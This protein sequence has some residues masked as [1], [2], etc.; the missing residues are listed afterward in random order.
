MIFTGSNGVAMTF[1]DGPA[2]EYTPHILDLLRDNGLKATFCVI[3]KNA[4]NHPDLIRRIHYEGHTLCNHSWRHDMELRKRGEAAIRDDLAATNNA[5]R[6]AVPDAKIGYFRAPGGHF[7]NGLVAIAKS[8]GMSSIY[9]DVDTRD[10]E[11]SKYGRGQTMVNHIVSTVQQKTRQGSIVLAH[12]YN[13][14]D[15]VTAFKYLMPWLKSRF[16][17]I[18]LPPGGLPRP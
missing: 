6:E 2:P 11:Y 15:T 7:D 1:D 14:P 16:T 9:W 12:D 17:I 8:M 3:G 4:H 13:K 10:W 18:A 5:I